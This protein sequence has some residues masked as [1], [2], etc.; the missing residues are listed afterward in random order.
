MPPS[1]GHTITGTTTPL[2]TNTS[3][4]S[5]LLSSAISSAHSSPLTST[6]G[7]NNDTMIGTR[8]YLPNVGIFALE[9]YFPSKFVDQAEFEQSDGASLGQYT[10]GFGQTQLGVLDDREDINSMSLT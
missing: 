5:S 3:A 2:S 8:N 4:A 10:I 1:P 9:V 6:S 7:D